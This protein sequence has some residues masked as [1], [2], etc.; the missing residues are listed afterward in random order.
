[1]ADR[2][3]AGAAVLDALYELSELVPR[4]GMPGSAEY[5]QF[6][7][8]WM[9][10][11]N[12]IQAA[13]PT[14]YS[15]AAGE[16][17]ASLW[18]EAVT[19]RAAKAEATANG[20]GNGLFDLLWH[21][22]DNLHWLLN[23]GIQHGQVIKQLP[24]KVHGGL[25]AILTPFSTPLDEL[26]T[27]AA[28]H[29]DRFPDGV[30]TQVG[31]LLLRAVNDLLIPRTLV[32]GDKL[33]SFLSSVGHP[34]AV[35]GAIGVQEWTGA[36]LNAFLDSLNGQ[37][38]PAQ[39]SE[40]TGTP[41]GS[42]K[43]SPPKAEPATAIENATQD[44]WI[45]TIPQLAVS[46]SDWVAVGSSDMKREGLKAHSLKAMRHATNDGAKKSADGT[47]GIDKAGRKWRKESANAHKVYY[48]RTTL[49]V[50]IPSPSL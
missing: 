18:L 32:A 4:G 46:S 6:M 14:I 40:A 49:K 44:D 12:A 7:A 26:R 24:A 43:E 17:L 22:D 8:R 15:P 25:A 10:I 20:R 21:D 31:M 47:A 39:V 11:R 3:F 50:D 2:L 37:A 36:A 19:R 30:A 23:D 28:A 5:P 16:G 41:T 33:D 42:V 35:L 45:A 38:K 9:T 1:M 29:P 13:A 34:P 27:L 48:L